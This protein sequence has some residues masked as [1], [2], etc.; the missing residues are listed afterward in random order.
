M[1]WRTFSPARDPEGGEE[2][3]NT[4]ASGS[5]LSNSSGS[6]LSSSLAGSS[7]V[8][9]RDKPREDEKHSIEIP[10]IEESG[11]RTPRPR[12]GSSSS[13]KSKRR[14]SLGFVP[15]WL[16][17]PGGGPAT[18]GG[19]SPASVEDTAVTAASVQD[20]SALVEPAL[21][22]AGEDSS[23][24][25]TCGQLSASF[26]P[27]GGPGTPGSQSHQGPL[28]S[29]F[30]CGIEESRDR[31]LSDPQR[32]SS[33]SSSS[34]VRPLVQS[35]LALL[36]VQCPVNGNYEIGFNGLETSFPVGY[37]GIN[38]NSQIFEENGNVLNGSDSFI[39]PA[40]MA[41]NQRPPSR[42]PPPLNMP[43]MMRP[44]PP[45]VRP[46]LFGAN[47]GAPPSMAPPPIPASPGG[48]RKLSLQS[49]LPNSAVFTRTPEKIGDQ[50]FQKFGDVKVRSPSPSRN[51]GVRNG[52][53]RKTSAPAAVS[54]SPLP[55]NMNGQTNGQDA[56]SFLGILEQ[57][58]TDFVDQVKKSKAFIANLIKDK[59]ELGLLV[60]NHTMKI[61]K[62]EGERMDYQKRII[63]AERLKRDFHDKL[64]QEKQNS[65]TAINNIEKQKEEFET[66]QKQSACVQQERNNAVHR[67]GQEMKN[68]ERLE[69]EKREMLI[70]VNEISRTQQNSSV[71][72]DMAKQ[73]SDLNLKLNMDIS[74]LKGENESLGKK[75]DKI[76]SELSNL[77]NQIQAATK[78]MRQKDGEIQSS[79]TRVATL[80]EEADR[81]RKLLDSV[82]DNSSLV[83]VGS[84]ASQILKSIEE[85]KKH[86][87]L[88]GEVKVENSQL[89][90]EN[91]AATDKIQK[92]QK[93][94]NKIENEK[95]DNISKIEAMHN[96]MKELKL[97][98]EKFESQ[99]SL[100]IAK[101]ESSLNRGLSANKELNSK[102]EQEKRM[103]VQLESSNSEL[104]E[105]IEKL[106]IDMK[107]Q[108]TDA[109]NYLDTVTKKQKVEE[110]LLTTIQEMKEKVEKY[111]DE[112]K[113]IVQAERLRKSS[114]ATQSKEVKLEYEEKVKKLKTQFDKAAVESK[115]NIN[116][117]TEENTKA[118]TLIE[119]LK[120]D[121]EKKQV[122]CRGLN[123]KLSSM[124]KEFTRYKN[125]SKEQSDTYEKQIDD[126]ES[127]IGEA[128]RNTESWKRKH[129][130]VQTDLE[131][132]IKE[133]YKLKEEIENLT[134][135][136]SSL[137]DG[138]QDTET[139][140][141]NDISKLETKLREANNKIRTLETEKNDMKRK[142]DGQVDELN[143]KISTLREDLKKSSTEKN[144][145]NAKIDRMA[146]DKDST[147]SSEIESRNRK[148]QE[149]EEE[150][151]DLKKSGEEKEK[152]LKNDLNKEVED[153]NKVV[154]N[155]NYEIDK[156]KSEV[157]SKQNQITKL[158]K[159]KRDVSVNFDK[160]QKKLNEVDSEKTKMK[161]ALFKLES[162]KKMNNFGKYEKE[163]MTLEIDNLTKDKQT[164]LGKLEDL[165]KEKYALNEKIKDLSKMEN[166]KKELTN[167]SNDLE[168]SVS[169]LKAKCKELETNNR[170]EKDASKTKEKT[171]NDQIR[172]ENNEKDKL[173]DKIGSLEENIKKYDKD[174]NKI[175]KD[176]TTAQNNLVEKEKECNGLK[177]DG[178]NGKA[179]SDRISVLE[180]QKYELDK[181]VSELET[182]KNSLTFKVDALEKDKISLGNKLKDLE[183][184]KSDAQKKGNKDGNQ[185]KEEVTK[186]HF[187]NGTLKKEKD[188]LSKS[189]K[190]I[191]KDL[192]KNIKDVKPNKIQG[193][194]R[195]LAEKIEKNT[196]V[197]KSTQGEPMVN[198]ISHVDQNE[199]KSNFN[200]LQKD[201]ET[202]TADIERLTSQLNRA[203][204]DSNNAVEKL[205]KSE[206]ELSEIKEKNAQLS[207]ELLNK[208]RKIAGM[209]NSGQS[210]SLEHKEL[211][212]Q[213]DDLKKK[214]A[215]AKGGKVKKSV[216][217]SS[218]PE[219]SNEPTKSVKELEEA[220]DAAYRER[221]EIMETCKKEVEFHRTIASEL[222]TSLIND[223][224]WK[225]HEMEKDY[226]NKLKYSKETIDEQI[227][228]ACRGILKEKDQ[229]MGKLQMKLRKE[230]DEKLKKDKEDL[231][232]ALENAK[233]GDKSKLLEACKVEQQAEFNTKQKKWEDKKKKYH[234][235]VDELKKK[236]KEKD[237]GAKNQPTSSQGGSDSALLEE[238]KRYDKMSQKFQEDHDKVKEDLN[239]QM[240]RLRAEY[241]E[242]IEEYEKKL[243]KAVADKVEKMLVLREEVEVEY[244]DKM[245]ELRN[246]YRDEMN[247]Q[248]EA[249][250]KAKTKM[251]QIE[252]SLQDS[253]RIKRQDYEEVKAKCDGAV[254]QVED[255][256]RRLN[257]QTAEVLRLQTELDGYEYE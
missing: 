66:L 128:R 4:E 190:Q 32:S 57:E 17:G 35:P 238:R 206:S 214:L 48:S 89:K 200:A 51:M 237:N 228:E 225:L 183:N 53:D 16:G 40:T 136:V 191:E 15:K 226:Y 47:P 120:I 90:S 193:E 84:Q 102:L 7:D 202:K 72:M 140:Q 137:K 158:E 198:G 168:T 77:E 70:K 145:L 242:K 13:T 176:L 55:F 21:T 56:H 164:A 117:L 68:L 197:Q 172:A 108:K 257:N 126:V 75:N 159:E 76:M 49:P 1:I 235:E 234:K 60:A 151:S 154:N 95:R 116:S 223:F 124:E 41:T 91:V 249:A 80:T 209:E 186:L 103:I 143:T 3:S 132:T 248:V 119:E 220:L 254:T 194:L 59:E 71:N 138:H 93:E 131:N 177:K 219:V 182:E 149:K 104:K 25:S 170:K 54:M 5:G 147:I 146:T 82:Q 123:T 251:Q 114:V 230:S 44:A 195:K 88:E 92:L 10:S 134:E 62:L 213:V 139:Q 181:N 192:K 52:P 85:S 211:Q 8:V 86:S 31:F 217:F 65:I 19:D 29:D 229:E 46:M 246:M 118:S 127:K 187:E 58:N 135:E 100:E 96:E 111:E 218:E 224:E 105:H 11:T 129:D 106:D 79:T 165:N 34:A 253:L 83:G 112:K 178:N 196:L 94:I 36:E 27:G 185:S 231:Q 22:A 212:L 189:L 50:K 207:D 255:L 64:E 69:Q 23:C 166:I 20:S 61:N 179:M 109:K 243:E 97:T 233:S 38:S 9:K 121:L 167:K 256:E 113:A 6:D 130:S 215:E 156:I 28:V 216:K 42:P 148:I 240:N 78:S 169:D 208:S 160:T 173:Q 157:N 101:L 43:Q 125:W 45:M 199:L 171:L 180:K 175:K 133:K 98:M 252:S 150:I 221:K 12:R 144:E 37:D 161:D 163:K 2:D 122:E 222:Q 73:A 30:P 245:D 141:R 155:F 210:G 33:S 110:E 188:E 239:G 184:S 18:A 227:K 247:N 204:S 24:R 39:H 14:K 142:L 26:E 241:D 63:E 81:L 203:K 74:V 153:K 115:K 201:F 250:E 107:K 205:R 174:I 99:K 152:K 232:K 236:L 87:L 67:L 162:E 244:A